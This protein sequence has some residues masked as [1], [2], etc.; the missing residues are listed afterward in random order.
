MSFEIT[1]ADVWVGEVEEDRPGAV[2]DKLETL[3]RAGANLEF[4]VLRPSADPASTAGVLVVAP[5]IGPE[6]EKAAAEAGLRGGV[7]ALRV[8]GPDRPGLI[9]GVTR[10]LADSGINVCGLWAATFGDHSVQYLSLESSADARR[11]AQILTQK[12]A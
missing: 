9:A 6:Q 5:L 12:L 1:T 10:T 8:V 3:M 4:A 2:A 7:H 11:A